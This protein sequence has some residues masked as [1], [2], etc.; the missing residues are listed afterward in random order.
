[1]YLVELDKHTGLV[2]V[3]GEFDGVRA[4]KEFREV[5]NH[6][7]LGV[8]CFTAIALTVDYL[9]PIAH[10]KESDRPYKAME[11]ATKGNRRAFVWNQDLIQECLI[12]YNELQYNPS[13]EEKRTLDFMLL[14]KLKEIKEL[15]DQNATEGMLEEVTEE[16]IHEVLIDNLDVKKLLGDREWTNLSEVAQKSFIRKANTRIIAPYNQRLKEKKSEKDEERMLVLFKQLNTIKALIENFNKANEDSDLLADG[17]VRN[18]YKL[19][20]LEEKA[21]N[22]NS[23]YHQE[24]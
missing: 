1:M 24:H 22:E 3:D 10:Y 5:I 18:G 23:F 19:T 8:V 15:K 4:I 6:P 7:D 12:K 14:E 16:T 21:E 17:P 11:Q 2:K 20:R 13:L 9:T